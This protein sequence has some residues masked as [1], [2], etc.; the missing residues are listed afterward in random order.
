[1]ID[2][3]NVP[4]EFILS[5]L[6]LSKKASEQ[7]SFFPDFVN[8][9]DELVL[10]FGEAFDNLQLSDFEPNCISALKHLNDYILSV[11]GSNCPEMWTTE[12]LNS[13]VEW[14]KIRSLASIVIDEFNWIDLKVEVPK[15]FEYIGPPG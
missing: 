4:K 1:M 11:S 5:V 15:S 6:A 9:A 2:S 3:I 14:S 10:N 7:R 13:S 12:A 8:V